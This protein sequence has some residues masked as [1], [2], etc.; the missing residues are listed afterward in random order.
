VTLCV[1]GY[2]GNELVYREGLHI[3]AVAG[4][5]L[6]RAPVGMHVP[7]ADFTYN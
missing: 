6:A 1:Y 4:G 2:A 7:T 3:Y 5:N